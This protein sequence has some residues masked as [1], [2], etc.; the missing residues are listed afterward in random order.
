MK[1]NAIQAANAERREDV[2]M[3][4]ATY[5]ALDCRAARV[6]VAESPS[7][8]GMRGFRRSAL[9]QTDF[10]EHSPEGQRH[11]VAFR[12]K[13]GPANVQRPC[14]HVVAEHGR[15]AVLSGSV[16]WPFVGTF[17]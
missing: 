4:Q 15:E 2:L 7:A 9:S 8:L 5:L 3:L 6:Q 16:H 14:S 1:L 17:R 11:F 10:G 12:W 13:V